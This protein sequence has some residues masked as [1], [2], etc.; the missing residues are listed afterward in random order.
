MLIFLIFYLFSFQLLAVK[1]IL[2]LFI[3]QP[4]KQTAASFAFIFAESSKDKT[5]LMAICS[6]SSSFT[7]GGGGVCSHNYVVQVQL[8][9]S[10]RS[11]G[12]WPDDAGETG[13]NVATTETTFQVSA[14]FSNP[15]AVFHCSTLSFQSNELFEARWTVMGSCSG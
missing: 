3:S 11:P 9:V 1:T 4:P 6:S 10:V 7:V 5:T 8:P 15:R 12:D 14:F 2:S 13:Q